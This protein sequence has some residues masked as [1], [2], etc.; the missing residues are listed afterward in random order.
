MALLQYLEWV[1][2]ANTQHLLWVSTGEGGKCPCFARCTNSWT[3]Y[4]FECCKSAGGGSILQQPCVRKPGVKNIS[5]HMESESLDEYGLDVREG[6]RITNFPFLNLQFWYSSLCVV[7]VFTSPPSAD[8]YVFHMLAASGKVELCPEK[9]MCSNIVFFTLPWEEWMITRSSTILEQK[10][11]THR[12][13]LWTVSAY[14]DTALLWDSQIANI[15]VSFHCRNSISILLSWKAIAQSMGHEFFVF[16]MHVIEYNNA[17]AI[18]IG[19]PRCW[20]CVFDSK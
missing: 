11:S 19:L 8:A 9:H 2:D 16:Q 13:V 18:D 20:K 17:V 14:L 15:Y 3:I 6:S 12:N 5:H 4:S 7:D 1:L 10:F